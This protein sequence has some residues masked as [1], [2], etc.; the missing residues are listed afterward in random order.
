LQGTLDVS[1]A[2][3]QLFDYEKPGVAVRLL[4]DFARRVGIT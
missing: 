4:R 3:I 1:N 2:K